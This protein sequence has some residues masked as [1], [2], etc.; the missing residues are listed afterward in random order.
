M[1]FGVKAALNSI[2]E[3]S[4]GGDV[5]V[6][7]ELVHNPV[8]QDHLSTR[9]V[10]YGDSERVGEAETGT[11]VFTAH[12]VSDRIRNRWAATGHSVIDTTCPLVKKAHRSLECLV[13][14]GYQPVVIGRREHTEVK[15]LIGDFPEAQVV[16]H[17]D[18]LSLIPGDTPKIG[19]I[20]QTT[21][22]IS[23]VEDL[24]D[25]IRKRF[26]RAEVRFVDTVCQPTKDRQT[27]M[28]HLCRKCDTIVVVGG[29]NSNNTRQLVEN[30]RARG[31][32][33]VHVITA[34]ELKPARFA[35]CRNIGVTAGTS[36]LD[37]TVEEVVTT[38]RRFSV[39]MA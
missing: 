19:V 39:L 27:A 30:A 38:L 11:V 1:C 29:R 13:L 22:P 3:I 35:G 33:T 20:S 17:P 16:L 14:A 9:G 26:S 5:T 6:L 36:T 4:S 25:M 28:D 34:D 7:G 12:G 10:R 21:Q 23:L 15:G 2:D 18:D 31:C 32:D 8:V 37:E 24:V